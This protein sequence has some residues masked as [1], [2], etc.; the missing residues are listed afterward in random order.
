MNI[1]KPFVQVQSNR[2]LIWK[3]TLISKYIIHLRVQYLSS[4]FM[5]GRKNGKSKKTFDYFQLKQRGPRSNDLLVQSVLWVVV[6][7]RLSVLGFCSR[8][9]YLLRIKGLWVCFWRQQCWF[10]WYCKT[11]WYFR[12]NTFCYFFLAKGNVLYWYI[13]K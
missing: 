1:I 13:C 5:E 2:S 12:L 4:E 8:D 9:Y 11:Y 7:K 10:S 3:L 6:E